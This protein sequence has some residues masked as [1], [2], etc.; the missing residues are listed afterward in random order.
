MVTNILLKKKIFYLKKNLVIYNLKCLNT[1][2]IC[3][4]LI[5]KINTFYFSYI[6]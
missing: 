5:G 4:Y 1:V 2:Y 3:M 6:C